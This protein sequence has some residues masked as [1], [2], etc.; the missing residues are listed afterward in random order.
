MFTLFVDYM[1]FLYLLLLVLVIPLV[2]VKMKFLHKFS[3]IK[4]LSWADDLLHKDRFC[5][6]SEVSHVGIG[7]NLLY[8][9]HPFTNWS[10]NPGYINK[11]GEIDHTRE[12][13]RRVDKYL[14]IYDAV[15]SANNKKLKKI[16][17]IGGSTTYCT[18]LDGYK[19]SWPAK[20][21][22]KF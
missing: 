17:C 1:F 16:V 14:S 2:F 11:Y 12:G 19:D 22:S 8:A 18:E 6:Y 4:R 10:L 15:D 9:P 7:K 3:I 21:Q 5:A 20:L 13:F